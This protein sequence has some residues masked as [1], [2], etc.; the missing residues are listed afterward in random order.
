ME[1]GECPRNDRIFDTRFR[2]DPLFP[3]GFEGYREI[4]SSRCQAFNESTGQSI[5]VL[6]AAL[7]RSELRRE[8]ADIGKLL[9][10]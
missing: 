8:S 10:L 1:S 2:L 4:A 3:T 5:H 6:A 7:N 9:L